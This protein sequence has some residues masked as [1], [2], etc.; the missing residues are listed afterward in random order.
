M[1]TSSAGS[2]PGAAS[3]LRTRVTTCEAFAKASG[4]SVSS[5]TNMASQSD[6]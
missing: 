1:S 6:A 3:S 2:G 4:S 5:I